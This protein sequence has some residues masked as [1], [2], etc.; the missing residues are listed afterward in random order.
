[1]TGEVADIRPYVAASA[2]YVVPLRSGGGTRHKILQAMAMERPV[3]S[4]TLGAEGLEVTP[5]VNI[6]IADNAEQFINRVLLLLTSS[7][8]SD[9]IAMAGRQLVVDNY[10][11]DIC[12]HRLDKLHET[13]LSSKT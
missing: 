6:L 12:L 2:A 4:T 3:I 8:V 13:V 1:M 9:R 7:E 11:W 10:H 5:E